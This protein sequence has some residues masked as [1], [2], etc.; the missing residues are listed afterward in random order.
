MLEHPKARQDG[1]IIKAKRWKE[2]LFLVSFRARNTQ[3]VEKLHLQPWHQKTDLG[4]KK[5]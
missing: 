5:C 2:R 3:I 4:H 1:I